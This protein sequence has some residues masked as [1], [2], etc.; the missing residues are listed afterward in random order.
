[1]GRASV[2]ADSWEVVGNRYRG[3]CD[4]GIGHVAPSRTEPTDGFAMY[5]DMTTIV[6]AL[7]TAATVTSERG[8]AGR[9]RHDE[10]QVKTSGLAARTHGGV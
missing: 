2:T 10:P 8:G 3:T 6:R 9:S 5:F 1:M 4:E 7:S